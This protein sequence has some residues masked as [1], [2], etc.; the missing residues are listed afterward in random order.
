M[1]ELKF[2]RA[3]VVNNM[4][5]RKSITPIIDYIPESSSE[6]TT[7]GR[8]SIELSTGRCC[9]GCTAEVGAPKNE[10]S[11][12]ICCTPA[13]AI[14]ESDPEDACSASTSLCVV[15]KNNVCRGSRNHTGC[16]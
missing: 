7:R 9:P 16:T 11:T 14:P 1:I 6:C 5:S 3:R 8:V 15:N 2:A 4:Q 13:L 12:S 10:G